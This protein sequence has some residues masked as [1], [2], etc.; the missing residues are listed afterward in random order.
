VGTDGQS[1]VEV[2]DKLKGEMSK[3]MPRQH[4]VSINIQSV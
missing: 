3:A 1:I 4:M 2:L